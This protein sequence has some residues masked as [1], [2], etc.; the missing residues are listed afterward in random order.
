LAETLIEPAHEDLIRRM[1]L[2]A[3]HSDSELD[4]EKIYHY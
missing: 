3:I 1:L 2:Y 4:T